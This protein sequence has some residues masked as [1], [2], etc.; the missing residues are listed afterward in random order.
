MQF[1][2]LFPRHYIP[3]IE[4]FHP[5]VLM[6]RLSEQIDATIRNVPDFPE[7]GIQYKDITPV[8][9]DTR[10]MRGIIA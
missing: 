1:A 6:S 7:P 10:L 5:E 4:K 8:L 3:P 9:A 2:K